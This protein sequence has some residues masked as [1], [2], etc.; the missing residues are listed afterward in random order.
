MVQC[1][2]YKYNGKICTF[3]QILNGWMNG[4]IP[5]TNAT[6]S[7]YTS[8]FA[9]WGLWCIWAKMLRFSFNIHFHSLF[10][11]DLNSCYYYIDRI[12]FRF[13]FGQPKIKTNINKK[14]SKTKRND[15]YAHPCIYA[16]IIKCFP[17]FVGYVK[18]IF[19][20]DEPSA[21]WHLSVQIIFLCCFCCCCCNAWNR[22]EQKKMY[23]SL[24]FSNYIAKLDEFW[25]V[26]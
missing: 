19:H 10:N 15:L 20:V 16:R 12:V 14:M 6:S 25:W 7:M 11:W 22:S 8:H 9:L 21:I 26:S 3:L 4:K 23:V 1:T 5:Q 2:V 13:R 17:V 24:L 18:M